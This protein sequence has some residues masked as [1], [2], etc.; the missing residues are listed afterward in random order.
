MNLD[1]SKSYIP[2]P[3]SMESSPNPKVHGSERHYLKKETY[4]YRNPI[5][6]VGCQSVTTDTKKAI[7]RTKRCSSLLFILSLLLGNNIVPLFSSF[8]VYQLLVPIVF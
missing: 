5:I 3:P 8:P 1:V 2:C 7:E 4:R 6:S